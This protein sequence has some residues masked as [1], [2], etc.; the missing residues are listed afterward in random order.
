MQTHIQREL[1]HLYPDIDECKDK[2][3][4][5]CSQRCLNT[6]GSYMCNCH[7]GYTLANDNKTCNGK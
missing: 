7:H 5:G 2:V 3:K 4:S 6:P 1:Y